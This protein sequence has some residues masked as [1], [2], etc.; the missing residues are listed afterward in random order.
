[1]TPFDNEKSIRDKSIDKIR[2]ALWFPYLSL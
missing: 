1:M 2:I